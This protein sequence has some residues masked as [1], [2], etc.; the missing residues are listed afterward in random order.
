MSEYTEV[1]YNQ[2]IVIDNGTGII[3]AGFSGETKPTT[4][5]FNIIGVPKYKKIMTTATS[6]KDS[7]NNNTNSAN[8]N[9]Q[10][11]ATLESSNNIT[12]NTGINERYVGNH[13]QQ[14]RGILKLQCPMENGTITNWNDMELIWQYILNNRLNLKSQDDIQ[15]H[16]LLITEVPM[17]QRKNRAIMCEILFENIE[18]PAVYVAIPGILSLYSSGRTTGC[19]LDSG[20]GCS[21]AVS[22][23]DGY[24]IPTSIKRIDVGGSHIT[25]SLQLLLRKYNGI[26][27]FSSSERELCRM[28]K[29]TACYVSPKDNHYEQQ[30]IAAA[31]KFRLPDGQIIQMNEER[32]LSPEILFKPQ[33]FGL[34]CLGIHN[35]VHQSINKVDIELRSTLYENIILTGGNTVMENF[36]ERLCTELTPLIHEGT[37]LKLYAPPE[38]KYS[39]WVGGSILAGLS[40]FKNIWLT[41]AEYQENPELI[42][43]QFLS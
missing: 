28:I 15:E 6:N 10:T 5:E 39:S 18:V 12:I 25:D 37:S 26:S 8:V 42:Q 43:N 2:P 38:R 29:E 22:V 19:I 21:Y 23:Y 14:N 33:N 9:S 41:K 4:F 35:L 7:K 20:E 36:G 32:Y 27:L 11:S 30:I 24:H 13:A 17:N 3:K 16:P 40:S 31:Q 1:L 34:E